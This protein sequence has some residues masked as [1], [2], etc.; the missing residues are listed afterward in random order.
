MIGFGGTADCRVSTWEKS[1]IRC[2]L[3]RD[4]LECTLD[5][6]WIYVPCAQGNWWVVDGQSKR[7]VKKIHTGGR[8]HNTVV[9]HDGNRMYLARLGPPRAVTI[10]DVR[11]SHRVIGE[12]PFRDTTRPAAISTL[13]GAS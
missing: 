9:S 5:E 12:I 1:P 6:K 8:P 13:A 10:V 2:T 7:V 4:E 3:S 11:D